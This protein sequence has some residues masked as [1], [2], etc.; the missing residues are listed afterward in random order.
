MTP[1]QKVT[2]F[3]LDGVPYSLLAELF[4][5]GVMPRL[6]EAAR[7]GS[8]Q[9][10]ETDLPAV[11]S[12]AWTSFM[13]GENPGRHRI[14]GF[15]DVDVNRALKLPSFDDIR[16]P[17]VWHKIPQARSLIINLPFTYPARPLQGVLISGFVAPV[18]ERA[19]YPESLIPWLKSFDYRI[20]VDSVRGRTDRRG[21][22]TELFEHV[23][24]L[25]KV[26]LSLA[27]SQ[28]WELCIVV[29]T[30]T[31]RL[32]HFFFDAATDPDHPF[33]HDFIDYYRRVDGFYGRF[34]DSAPKS[35]SLIA[36]S[37]HGFTLLKTQVYVNHLLHSMGYLQLG[38]ST[39]KEPSDLH[40][41]T[42]AFALDPGRIYINSR[43]RFTAGGVS[44][45]EKWA[46][47]ARLKGELAQV[48]LRDIGVT[49]PDD[50][51]SPDDR[52]FDAVLA[53][54]EIYDGDCLRFAP[55]LVLVPRRGY[56]LKAALNVHVPSRRD[57]FTGTH[58]HDDAFLIS[59]DPTLPERLP[60]PRIRDVA[61]LIEQSSL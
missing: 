6:A 50:D 24:A 46:L 22:I 33:Y 31:D 39:A 36:L 55:D 18:F 28:P 59:D 58:T 47:C 44:P 12:V 30:G 11:S 54:E 21:L 34:R 5:A 1:R 19:V 48:R 25:E 35:A 52:L 42:R 26:T 15:T 45:E 56:D 20:D 23:N 10:M 32:H 51:D 8:F 16:Y 29:V 38:S 41:R 14:F 57:I 9:R 13:T 49:L 61:R 7:T 27:Q 2:V 37:D 17:T 40:P 4:A 3:G 60:R 43:D 53:A